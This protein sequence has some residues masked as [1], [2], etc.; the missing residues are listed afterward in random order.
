MTSFSSWRSTGVDGF[1]QA[2]IQD[3]GHLGP[4]GVLTSRGGA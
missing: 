1:S 2:R 4:S 3:F